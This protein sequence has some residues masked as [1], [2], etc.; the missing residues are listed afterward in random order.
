M[1]FYEDMVRESEGDLTD[2][3]SPVGKSATQSSTPSIQQN[4]SAVTGQPTP[5]EEDFSYTDEIGKMFGTGM[6]ETINA[7]GSLPSDLGITDKPIWHIDPL[8]E[9]PETLVG[10][11]GSTVVQFM[12]PYTGALKVMNAFKLAS[13]AGKAA[14]VGKALAAGAAADFVAFEAN[15]PFLSN[16]IQ[17]TPELQNPITEFLATD[18][19]DPA[20]MNRLRHAVEG[21]GLGLAFPKI[22]DGVAKLTLGTGKVAVNA[23][24]GTAKAVAPKFVQDAVTNVAGKA[25]EGAEVLYQKMVDQNLGS[26]KITEELS[27]LGKEDMKNSLTI[28]ENARLGNAKGTL[29]ERFLHKLVK[30]DDDAAKG[31]EYL[32]E[33]GD[34][35]VTILNKTASHGENALKDIENLAKYTQALQNKGKFARRAKELAAKRKDWLAEPKNK[36]KTMPDNL[37]KQKFENEGISGGIADTEVQAFFREWDAKKLSDPAYAGKIGGSLKELKDMNVNLLKIMKDE[38]LID[39]ATMKTYLKDG[40]LHMYFHREQLAED[41]FVKKGAYRGDPSHQ[42]LKAFTE[43]EIGKV[44]AVDNVMLNTVRSHMKIAGDIIDNRIKRKTYDG[45]TDIGK[46]SLAK[47]MGRADAKAAMDKWAVKVDNPNKVELDNLRKNYYIDSFKR[48]GKDEHWIMKDRF[49]VDQMQAMGP[50][51]IS[52]GTMRILRVGRA[53]KTFASNLITM[54]PGFFLYANMLRDT[55]SVS[56]LSRSG[57]RPGVDSLKGLGRT[58]GDRLASNVKHTKSLFNPKD[59]TDISTGSNGWFQEMKNQGGTFGRQVYAPEGLI[60]GEEGILSKFSPEKQLKDVGVRK[61]DPKHILSV[62][63]NMRKFV[64]SAED[65]TSR[66]EYASRTEE[67]RRLVEVMGYSKLKA[68]ILSRDVAIDFGNRGTSSIFRGMTAMV[69]FLNAHVQGIARTLKA[70]GAKKLVGG[71]LTKVEREEVRR[72][73]EKTATLAQITSA[74]YFYH[75][76][77]EE[78][79]GDPSIK[80]IYDS[81]PDHVKEKNWIIVM[82]KDKEGKNWIYKVPTPFDFAAMPN[83]VVKMIQD[84][85][86]PEEQSLLADYTLRMFAESGRVG[87]TSLVP[88]AIRAPLDI[89]RNK[90]FAGG[91]II[92]RSLEGAAPEEQYLPWTNSIFVA[93]GEKTGVSPLKME[94]LVNSWTG[95]LG[96]GALDLVDNMMIR[97]AMGR[98]KQQPKLTDSLGKDF[99]YKRA[100]DVTPLNVTRQGEKMFD[101]A[102]EIKAAKAAVDR[103]STML[104]EFD[105]KKYKELTSDPEVQFHLSMAPTFDSYLKSVANMSTQINM[106]NKLGPDRMEPAAKM[107]QVA[108][109]VQARNDLLKDLHEVYGRER[110]AYERRQEQAK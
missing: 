4:I 55:V 21:L 19:K 62:T 37:K 70:Y 1:G 58:M 61:A 105:I 6:T 8:T 107:K 83:M 10:D 69:P 71:T 68:S 45:I 47:G 108:A 24:V 96:A 91:S 74:L 25:K 75:Q 14:K 17:E 86:D 103:H 80:E 31:G 78:L 23:S 60:R 89:S 92:P 41:G 77:S 72:V 27:A 20:A 99:F 76:K 26:K 87:D 33:V 100:M 97:G 95:T 30:F 53:F 3:M 43:D 59:Y 104:S 54:N 79:F 5:A 84:L 49:L 16:L 65:F 48:D 109:L 35:I 106:L 38:G 15:D 29:Q 44:A 73:Y 63:N 51:A 94:Y 56:I 32:T 42:K 11:I 39:D 22:I 98:P 9:K 7:M 82:P 81:T 18:E 36:G 67:Y 88:Q 66:F 28:Y 46:M 102:E 101:K 50:V 2:L 110:G 90:N 12:I 93:I 52:E 13:S 64:N 34:G 85:Y 40:D 57:F